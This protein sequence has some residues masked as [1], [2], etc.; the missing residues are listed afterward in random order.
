MEIKLSLR[1]KSM[2]LVGRVKTLLQKIKEAVQGGKHKT[3]SL[4]LKGRDERAKEKRRRE[5]GANVLV[6]GLKRLY[7]CL[8]HHKT[9]GL[10]AHVEEEKKEKVATCISP[11]EYSM[12]YY[13]QTGK[14]DETDENRRIS[15]RRRRRRGGGKLQKEQ[16]D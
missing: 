3:G 1:L 5:E 9:D 11:I 8:I 14:D 12:N 16:K 13:K 4:W 15:S 7:N 6:D 10:V 2:D